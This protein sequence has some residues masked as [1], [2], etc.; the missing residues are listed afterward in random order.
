MREQD[1]LELAVRVKAATEWKPSEEFGEL[2]E[3][4]SKERAQRQPTSARK[5]CRACI[6]LNANDTC[7]NFLSPGRHPKREPGE[8]IPIPRQLQDSIYCEAWIEVEL[9]RFLAQ[10]M[11]P[12]G[13]AYSRRHPRIE[14]PPNGSRDF[15]AHFASLAR[16]VSPVKFSL[17][18]LGGKDAKWPE[19][20]PGLKDILKTVER[21]GNEEMWSQYQGTLFMMGPVAYLNPMLDRLIQ[22]PDSRIKDFLDYVIKTH[23]YH[24]NAMFGMAGATKGGETFERIVTLLSDPSKDLRDIAMTLLQVLSKNSSRKPTANLEDPEVWREWAKK[25]YEFAWKVSWKK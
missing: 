3:N 11:G 6:F 7:E 5:C 24:Y 4:I 23:G 17:F 16:K 21:R 8:W 22:K 13:I 19:M 15:A 14:I 20:D 25:E 10:G 2:E 12:G 9:G 18:G 1:A